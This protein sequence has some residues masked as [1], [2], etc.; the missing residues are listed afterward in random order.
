MILKKFTDEV[1]QELQIKLNDVAGPLNNTLH[2]QVGRY[3]HGI[4]II[5]GI[6]VSAAIIQDMWKK[7]VSGDRGEYS[8]AQA[9]LH[10]EMPIK[11]N[12]Q[13]A[14]NAPEEIDA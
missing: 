2:E 3:H 4:G 11:A 10:P 13:E 1:I 9:P 12:I 14:L 7:Y 5:Q 6:K 8:G